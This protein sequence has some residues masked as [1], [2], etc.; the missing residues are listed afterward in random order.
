MEGP[1]QLW[2]G[3]YPILPTNYAFFDVWHSS[4]PSAKQFTFYSHPHKSHSRL[5]NFF[6]NGPNLRVCN[7]S[8]IQAISWSDHVPIMRSLAFSLCSFTVCHWRLNKFLLKHDPS[9]MELEQTLKL[10]FAE[11]SSPVCL[12]CFLLGRS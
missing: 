1:P 9:R 3:I 7:G 5:D 8:N 2:I 4:Y 11:N 12:L 6:V 10:C